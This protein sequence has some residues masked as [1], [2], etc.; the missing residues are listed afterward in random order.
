MLPAATADEGFEISTAAAGSLV[1]LSA[2]A[3]VMR[4]AA[5]TLTAVADM[6]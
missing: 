1:T 6:M 5:E 2:A 3:D 4:P